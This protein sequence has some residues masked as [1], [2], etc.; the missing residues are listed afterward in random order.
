MDF[1]LLVP[2]GQTETLPSICRKRLSRIL[3]TLVSC[4]LVILILQLV[5]V[6]DVFVLAL[7]V[8]ALHW[9]A[10]KS[11]EEQQLSKHLDF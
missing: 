4:L 5:L 3:D 1:L 11:L 7:I 10:S 2:F 6:A 8:Y 9:K